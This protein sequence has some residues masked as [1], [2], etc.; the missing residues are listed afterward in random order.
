MPFP[1]KI[2]C[3]V[4]TCVPSDN[5]FL[6]VRQEPSF[7]PWKGSPFL[8]HNPWRARWFKVPWEILGIDRGETRTWRAVQF[9][10]VAQ[11]C[12]TLHDPIDCT[13][14]G[15]SIH[16]D[17]PGKN[18]GVGCHALLQGIFPTQGSNPG[19]LPCRQILYCLSSQYVG[20]RKKVIG[21]SNTGA[22]TENRQKLRGLSQPAQGQEY[23]N[24][25]WKWNLLSHAQ[26]FA[27]PSTIQSMQF[28]R[29]ENWSG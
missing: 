28:S 22:R 13:P 5:L 2:S 21:S 3:F 1:N 29:P 11:S 19:P 25:K 27:T 17:S 26:L 18:T 15:S 20:E 4:N 23:K 7:G 6:R 10:S 9:S 24:L 8:Q 16:G 14:P 12:L